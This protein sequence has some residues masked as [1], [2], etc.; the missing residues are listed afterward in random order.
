[1]KSAAPTNEK[2]STHQRK[3]VEGQ[4]ELVGREAG[5]PRKRE[6]LLE[7]VQNCRGAL[8]GLQKQCRF[9]RGLW[10]AVVYRVE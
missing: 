3:V 8:P 7:C 4:G 2:C 6:L 9:S 10:Q 5:D 1:M